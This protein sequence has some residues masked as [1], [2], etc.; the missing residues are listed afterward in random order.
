MNWNFP[1]FCRGFE[2]QMLPLLCIITKGGWLI[3]LK[4]KLFLDH[5]YHLCHLTNN[6][7]PFQPKVQWG[8]M[9]NCC[10]V[11]LDPL[12]ILSLYWTQTVWVEV[13]LRRPKVFLPLL[14]IFISPLWM[15][16]W[17]PR[18]PA[19]HP[20]PP[21]SLSRIWVAV[22]VIWSRAACLSHMH[23]MLNRTVCGMARS[24]KETYVSDPDSEVSE[25][26]L[27]IWNISSVFHNL[28]LSSMTAN[29]TKPN[30]A[31]W[32]KKNESTSIF[33]FSDREVW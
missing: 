24:V 31:F 5:L 19:P 27:Q 1:D 13:W 22:S 14:S 12:Y 25:V 28:G 23:R 20:T 18:P 15:P 4:N 3:M 17:F 11:S 26:S 6:F 2:N 21:L 16:V 7:N 10:Y 9:Y 33:D 29:Q 30:K 8:V 32:G